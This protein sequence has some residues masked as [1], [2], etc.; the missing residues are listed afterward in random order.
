[1]RVKCRF[2]FLLLVSLW[3]YLYTAFAANKKYPPFIAAKRANR[4]VLNVGSV[5][6]GNFGGLAV[7]DIVQILLP[8]FQINASIYVEGQS[9]DVV[10]EGPPQF[11]TATGCEPPQIAWIQFIAEP[12]QSYDNS[13]WC[14][15]SNDALVRIDTSLFYMKNTSHQTVFIWYPYA[16]YT[17]K[18]FRENLHEMKNLFSDLERPYFLAWTAA[19]CKGSRPLMFKHLL[20]ELALLNVTGVHALGSCMRNTAVPIPSRDT[21]FTALPQVYKKYRFVLT[22]ES[23]IESGYVTEKII[24]ALAGGAIPVYIGDRHAVQ[25]MGMKGLFVDVE[26]VWK[27]EGSHAN[28]T[29]SR[30]E[31]WSHVA[32]SG[33]IIKATDK[34]D[35][36][37]TDESTHERT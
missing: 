35:Q 37:G 15:H 17:A 1:M 25:R 34:T 19:N 11:H 36:S 22:I 12:G 14:P 20:D 29:T 10:V 4:R 5:R 9:Y 21:G 26:G 28:A 32:H 7:L 16:M 13:D 23:Q 33:Q 6:N 30:R 3:F 27:T 31:D 24:T 18:L 2:I 8:G